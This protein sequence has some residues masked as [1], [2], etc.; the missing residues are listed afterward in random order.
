MAVLRELRWSLGILD[1]NLCFA[2]IERSGLYGGIAVVIVVGGSREEHGFSARE[3]LWPSM[4]GFRTIGA[5]RRWRYG[6]HRSPGGAGGDLSG[7]TVA[8][9]RALAPKWRREVVPN[10][11]D[12]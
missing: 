12:L 6:R 1:E 10:R 4:R 5:L 9:G 11:D 2:R 7:G 3:E 8:Q